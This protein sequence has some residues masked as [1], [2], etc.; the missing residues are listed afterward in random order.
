YN[1]QNDVFEFNAD[2]KHTSEPG[3]NPVE[4]L[5]QQVGGGGADDEQLYSADISRNLDDGITYYENQMGL[6]FTLKPQFSALQG[7]NVDGR[8]VYPVNGVNGQL[9]Y[10]VQPGGLKEDIVLYEYPGAD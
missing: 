6:S 9:I 5:Q 2:A 8:L 1:P 10:T 3:E 7:K 4:Q